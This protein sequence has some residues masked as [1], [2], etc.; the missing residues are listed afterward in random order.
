[1]RGNTDRP[2]EVLGKDEFQIE[3]YVTGLAEFIE[4][5]DTPM[6]IAIQG[7]WGCGKT[8]MMNMTRDCLKARKDIVDVWF[9]TWQFSQ[10]N[11]DE[12]LVVTFL[13]HLI[14][15][16]S[17]GIADVDL[18]EKL[19]DKFKPI[20]KSIAVGMTKQ[21][22][23]SDIG[24][25]VDS[26]LTKN[27]LDIVDKISELKRNFQELV[28]KT[29]AGGEKRVVVFIDDLDRL[30]PVRAVELL[31]ILKLFVDCDN[32]VFVMAIDTSVV[33][34]GIREK[35][36]ENMSDEKAQSFFDKM[37][38]MPFKMPVAYYKLGGMMERLLDFLQEESLTTKEKAEYVA[39]FKKVTNGNPRS[40][41]RLANTILLT[42][43]V[44]EKKE[45][46]LDEPEDRKL[47][48]RQ[49]LVTLSC[50]Q[51]KYEW[52]YNFLVNDMTY[53][54][55]DAI[56]GMNLPGIDDSKRGEVLIERLIEQGMPR[57]EIEDKLVF[58]DVITLYI[59]TLKAYIACSAR[60]DISQKPAI[61]QLLRIVTMNNSAED[62]DKLPKRNAERTTGAE[63]S[64]KTP[65]R[66]E[67]LAK[68][69]EGK[70]EEVYGLL[71][72]RGLYL[73]LDSLGKVGD[74][75]E[76]IKEM[77][78]DIIPLEQC[79][80]YQK[81]DDVLSQYDKERTIVKKED[82]AHIVYKKSYKAA[83]ITIRLEYHYG[84][85]SLTLQGKV[86]D[87]NLK[88]MEETTV[89]LDK[90]L[91]LHGKAQEMYSE[92]L[93]KD[94]PERMIEKKLNS[95]GGIVQL[96]F[97]EFPVLTEEMADAIVEYAVFAFK[98]L[99]NYYE[100]SG[101]TYISEDSPLG[102]LMKAA[103]VVGGEVK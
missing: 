23:G 8:S 85:R 20:M 34:Q 31:E 46:Y 41:K 94:I 65:F 87:N 21:F 30:Q 18:K 47:I 44:T 62:S 49:I 15:E 76:A 24:D 100:N 5:C 22:I 97:N 25:V 48:I 78:K 57:F 6:T 26:A 83:C 98:N 12:Q 36:G 42:E 95:E 27:E 38:Q 61:E 64:Q 67:C 75:Y 60:Y 10:F 29:T 69:V 39:L 2:V 50:I 79:V 28:Q 3:P 93:I 55:M 13:Q 80:L 53:K 81:I 19:K 99:E 91:W 9:N 11:M 86:T 90:L 35:Y 45:I 54:R 72:Q 77:K 88:P 74:G 4:E 7:D 92:K 73:P 16:L 1:M 56:L 70:Y 37:I 66:Y 63:T 71:T 89:L 14:G 58:Y 52:A 17:E 32:C 68:C 51:M 43:K 84:N 40:L 96:G 103:Q 33:F 82:C 101:T 102:M 59:K